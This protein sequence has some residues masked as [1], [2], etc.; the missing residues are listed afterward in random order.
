MN[1]KK[2]AGNPSGM[3]LRGTPGQLGQVRQDGSILGHHH[4]SVQADGNG[5]SAEA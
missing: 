3:D 1:E 5:M 2:M 4:R